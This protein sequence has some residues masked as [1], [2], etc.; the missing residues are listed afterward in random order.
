MPGTERLG[1]DT[2]LREGGTAPGVVDDVSDNTLDVTMAL[3]V[4]LRGGRGWSGQS[5]IPA[6]GSRR[7]LAMRK[8]NTRTPA[9]AA[10]SAAASRCFERARG[11]E[12]TR[13]ASRVS[14]GPRGAWRAN[15]RAARR[16]R[17]GAKTL[18]RARFAIP[19]GGDAMMAGN[20]PPGG[21]WLRPC[22]WR[23]SR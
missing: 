7:S 20:V 8:K 4:V 9:G 22:A 10:P 17:P 11:V 18:G 2:H 19:H 3:G 12:S 13:H 1:G 5:G 21:A 23:C 6:T 16:R 15:V 14:C